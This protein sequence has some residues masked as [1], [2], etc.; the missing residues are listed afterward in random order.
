MDS[1]HYFLLQFKSGENFCDSEGIKCF[2]MD[3]LLQI[4]LRQRVHIE[5]KIITIFYH[6]Q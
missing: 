5:N 6:K 1:K 3:Y 4:E 2:I